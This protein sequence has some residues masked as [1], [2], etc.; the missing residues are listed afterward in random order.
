MDKI[1][2]L[3]EQILSNKKNINKLLD[4]IQ[5]CEESKQEEIIISSMNSILKIFSLHLHRDK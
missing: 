3:E 1:Q 5:I 2:K 4:L